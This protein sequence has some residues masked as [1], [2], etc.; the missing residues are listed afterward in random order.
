MMT[1]ALWPARKTFPVG[2]KDAEDDQEQTKRFAFCFGPVSSS[3]SCGNGSEAGAELV[4]PVWVLT[5]LNGRT[6]LPNRT[7][8]AEFTAEGVVSGS[9]GCNDYNA[10]YEVDG[11]SISI[12]PAAATRKFCAEPEGVM[13]QEAEYLAALET[14]ATFKIE[15]NSVNMRKTDGATVANFSRTPIQ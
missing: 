8:S 15:V 6:P 1:S 12:G 11:E 7:I 10:S 9:A 2:D 14:A 3:L 5:N 13:E 4:G